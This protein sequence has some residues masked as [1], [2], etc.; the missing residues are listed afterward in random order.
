MTARPDEPHIGLIIEGAGDDSALP[1]LLRRHLQDAGDYRDVLGKGIPIKG[2]SNATK[3]NGIEG[4]VAVA[5]SRPGCLGI[6]VV[7]DTDDSAPEE[8]EEALRDRLTGRVAQPVA[9]ACAERDYEDWL[10]ASAETLA[11]DEIAYNEG[12]RGATAIGEAVKSQTGRAYTKPIWQPRLTHRMDINLARSRNS[13]LD[14]ML[15]EFNELLTTI[16]K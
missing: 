14:K 8:F 15:I 9:V 12:A 13:S 10:Y 7:L 11:L 4:Y 3:V 2:V 1:I 5:A 6:L 16:P